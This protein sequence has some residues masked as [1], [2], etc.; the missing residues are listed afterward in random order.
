MPTN[1]PRGQG[2]YIAE[3]TPRGLARK[4]LKEYRAWRSCQDRCS[5]PDN[6]LYGVYGRVGVTVCRKWR[7]SFAAFLAD[8]GSAPSADHGLDRI[9]PFGNYE[10]ENC[11]W[12]TKSEQSKNRRWGLGNSIVRSDEMI[13]MIRIIHRVENARRAKPPCHTCSGTGRAQ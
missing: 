8:M 5:N 6:T 13:R 11:R 3:A 2:E 12:L 1:G 7:L 10:P 4:N 9:N